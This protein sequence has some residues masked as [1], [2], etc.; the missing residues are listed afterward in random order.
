MVPL[1]GLVPR[2]VR[3]DRLTEIRQRLRLAPEA[4]GLD[5]TISLR[6]CRLTRVDERQLRR[7]RYSHSIVAGGLPETS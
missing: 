7:R 3:M 4:L 1:L 2:S 6:S 5:E